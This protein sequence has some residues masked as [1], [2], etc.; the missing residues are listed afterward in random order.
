MVYS[1]MRRKVQ[2]IWVGEQFQAAVTPEEEAVID[3]FCN[4]Q[5][6]HSHGKRVLLS[7]QPQQGRLCYFHGHWSP[8]YAHADKSH[9]HRA[10]STPCGGVLLLENENC[11]TICHTMIQIVSTNVKYVFPEPKQIPKSTNKTVPYKCPFDVRNLNLPSSAS[12]NNIQNL[13]DFFWKEPHKHSPSCFSLI[14]A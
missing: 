1:C 14:N 13:L 3:G 12:I 4:C 10:S 5:H 2:Q 7:L 11:L 9:L 8:Q 6:S